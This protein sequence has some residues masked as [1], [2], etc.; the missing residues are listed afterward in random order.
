[1][2]ISV[3]DHYSVNNYTFTNTE[4]VATTPKLRE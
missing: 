3:N 4:L 1:M 2:E